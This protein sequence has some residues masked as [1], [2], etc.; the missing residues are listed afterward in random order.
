MSVK[1][2]SVGRI[3]RGGWTLIG[4]FIL[5]TIAAIAVPDPKHQPEMLEFLHILRI[6]VCGALLVGIVGTLMGIRRDQPTL[7]FG[8]VTL[9]IVLF[10]LTVGFGGGAFDKASTKNFAM[11]LKPRLKAED[12]VYCVGFYAQDLPVYLDRLVSVVEY[13]GELDFGIRAEPETTGDRFMDKVK[14]ADQWSRPGD[15]YAVVRKTTFDGWFSKTVPPFEILARTRRFVLVA[16]N[17]LKP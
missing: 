3:R 10:L 7:V 6:A 9:S 17:P 16:K 1:E 12:R 4:F 15:A 14:F 13:S 2:N 11:I 5:L 8:S